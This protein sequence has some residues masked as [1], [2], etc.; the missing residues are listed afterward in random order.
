MIIAIYPKEL[1]ALALKTGNKK[2]I[3]LNELFL[4]SDDG[5]KSTLLYGS[6][7]KGLLTPERL[8]EHF[9][10]MD[11]MDCIDSAI[12]DVEDDIEYN[13]IQ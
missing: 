1:E 11:L 4:K 13:R 6:S 8:I 9:C 2:V 7:F 10:D 3:K 12:E 5:M